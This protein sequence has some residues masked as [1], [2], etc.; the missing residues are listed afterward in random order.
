[1]FSDRVIQIGLYVVV[2]VNL[3]LAVLY[4][5]IWSFA[6]PRRR[7]IS[8]KPL[9]RDITRVVSGLI[10]WF[11][12]SKHLLTNEGVFLLTGL[13]AGGSTLLVELLYRRPQKHPANDAT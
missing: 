8:L 4:M 10:G 1:M 2:Y 12:F 9:W 11:V 5:A 6:G 7:S 3:L 13:L